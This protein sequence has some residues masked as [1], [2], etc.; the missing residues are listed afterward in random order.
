MNYLLT[1]G[2]RSGLTVLLVVTFTFFIL[3]LS[4]DPAMMIL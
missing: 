1:R 2:A 3:R 4:G